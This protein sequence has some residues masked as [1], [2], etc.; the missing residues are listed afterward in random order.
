MKNN[1]LLNGL[2]KRDTYDSLT[3]YLDGGQERIKYPDRLA[4]QLRNSHELSDLLDNEGKGWFEENKEQMRRFTEQQVHDIV[5]KEN[6][7][8]GQTF[9]QQ[10]ILQ[11]DPDIQHE[12][13]TPQGRPKQ[14]KETQ[15]EQGVERPP[16]N[17]TVVELFKNEM[18]NK[19][20]QEAATYVMKKA[21]EKLPSLIA[22]MV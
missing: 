11:Q 21:I 17:P 6:L 22:S 7:E 9:Q 2:R 5:V 12:L 20:A 18:K 3:G 1:I 8:T 16:D 14:L 13:D 19:I 4:T 15:R 10:Q